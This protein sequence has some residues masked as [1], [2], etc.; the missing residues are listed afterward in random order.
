ML[1]AVDL[2]DKSYLWLDVEMDRA[3]A[4]VEN[5]FSNTSEIL[6]AVLDPNRLSV[7][8]LL[9]LHVDARGTQVEEAAEADLQFLWEEF[10][11]DYARVAR[12]MTVMP[13]GE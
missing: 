7:Y 8:D 5:T 4:F 2:L 3:Y 6:S 12:F 11:A 1:C 10:V 13:T 9:K